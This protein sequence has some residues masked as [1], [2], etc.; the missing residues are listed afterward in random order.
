MPRRHLT[1]G[2]ISRLLQSANQVADLLGI[3]S[4]GGGVTCEDLKA[5]MQSIAGVEPDPQEGYANTRL[6]R[7]LCVLNSLRADARILEAAEIQAR[8]E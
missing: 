5:K 3:S 4:H 2:N 8:E 6:S 7:L 1:V